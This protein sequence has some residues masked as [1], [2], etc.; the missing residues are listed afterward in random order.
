MQA[1]ANRPRVTVQEPLPENQFVVD[2]RESMPQQA[3]RL[4]TSTTRGREIAAARE[5]QMEM[6][7][8]EE[9]EEGKQQKGKD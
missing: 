5:G 2:E 8:E 1:T 6:Q 7:R 3:T 4:I 9:A